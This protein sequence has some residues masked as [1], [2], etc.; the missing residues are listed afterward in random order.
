MSLAN[1]HLRTNT[2]PEIVN[3]THGGVVFENDSEAFW[4]CAD[5]AVSSTSGG[6]VYFA[7]LSGWS[8]SS[9][10]QRSTPTRLTGLK[11]HL[12]IQ[13]MSAVSAKPGIVF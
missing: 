6:V 8:C 2:P 7:R 5:R 12:L 10:G 11:N 9:P 1:Q 3:K 13:Y 4:G